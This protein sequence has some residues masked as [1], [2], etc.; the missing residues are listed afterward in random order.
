MINK[1]EP[2]LITVPDCRQNTLLNL[3]SY[4]FCKVFS[5]FSIKLLKKEKIKGYLYAI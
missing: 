3:Y 4:N 5:I 2:L 1:K